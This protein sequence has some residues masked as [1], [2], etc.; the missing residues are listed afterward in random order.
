LFLTAIYK[1][2]I[3]EK[4]HPSAQEKGAGLKILLAL[5]N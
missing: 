4:L 3:A 1:I 2:F 5:L